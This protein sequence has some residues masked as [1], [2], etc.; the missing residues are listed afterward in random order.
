MASRKQEIYRELLADSISY[1]RNLASGSPVSKAFDKSSFVEL[2]FV[3]SIPESILQPDFVDH[4][5]WFLNHQARVFI[6]N[7]DE[8]RT[9][10]YSKYRRRIIE[11][12]GLLDEKQLAEID[13][14]MR[15]LIS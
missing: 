1:C 9:P 10:N 13:A 5:L 2:Q 14:D 15:D 6:F 8:S 11:L 4:D 7:A 12:L 3:H